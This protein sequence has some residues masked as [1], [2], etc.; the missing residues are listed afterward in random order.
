MQAFGIPTFC[1]IRD[2]YT[3]GIVAALCR[4]SNPRVELG[5]GILLDSRVLESSLHHHRPGNQ[6]LCPKAA[7]FISLQNRFMTNITLRDGFRNKNSSMAVRLL[8]CH[9]NRLY[10]QS[11]VQAHRLFFRMSAIA[12]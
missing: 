11:E 5:Q 12:F 6:L 10:K 9:Q 4:S 7:L 3:L 8:F 1:Y 2:D